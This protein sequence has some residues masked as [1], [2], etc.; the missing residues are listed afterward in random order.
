MKHIVLAL[1]ILLAVPAKSLALT[2]ICGDAASMRIAAQVLSQSL[3]VRT[4]NGLSGDTGWEHIQELVQK[5]AFKE[6]IRAFHKTFAYAGLPYTGMNEPGDTFFRSGKYHQAFAAYYQQH[7]C[8]KSSLYAGPL[9]P[10]LVDDGSARQY[11]TALEESYEG[12][13]RDAYSFINAALK[14]FSSNEMLILKG[15]IAWIL[16]DKSVSINA[17]SYVATHKDVAEPDIISDTSFQAF[18]LLMYVLTSKGP[19]TP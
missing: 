15:E 1:I 2:P 13:L 10:Q 6:S 14:G 5:K 8:E 18:E 4:K 3:G 11:Q 12:G 16:G 17:F 9:N 7:F 19:S